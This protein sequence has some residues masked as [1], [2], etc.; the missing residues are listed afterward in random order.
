M[1]HFGIVSDRKPEGC[2]VRVTLEELDNLATD[3][4]PVLQRG[5]KSNKGY[6]LPDIGEHVV[7]NTDEDIENGVVIGTIYNSEDTP[8]A[9]LAG[10]GVRAL[11]LVQDGAAVFVATVKA[12]AGGAFSLWAKKGISVE[13][14]SANLTLAAGTDLV[15]SAGGKVAV[16]S[17]EPLAITAGGE[18]GYEL[19][20][21]TLDFLL[22][23]KHVVSGPATT[24][25]SP[26]DIATLTKLN[27]RLKK[28]MQK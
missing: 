20:A 8:D 17:T 3:W 4:L 15:A 26:A 11:K 14:E 24:V 21:D 7:I 23:H 1:L 28:F 12:A 25:L 16:S 19:L 6:W 18:S 22:N 13:S 9:A 5:T 2:L 10:I 27:V